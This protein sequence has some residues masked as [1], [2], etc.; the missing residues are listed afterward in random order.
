MYHISASRTVC[1]GDKMTR[2]RSVWQVAAAL[3][4]VVVILG[5]VRRLNGLPDGL[6]G[7]YY[8]TTDW[9]GGAVL[10]AVDK[11]PS[12]AAMLSAWDPHSPAGVQRCVDELAPRARRTRRRR[13][14]T[15]SELLARLRDAACQYQNRSDVPRPDGAG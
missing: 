1:G 11:Q 13:V 6:T 10:V 2:V 3:T 15:G 12:T 5:A 4:I 9:T 8:R 7:T 14:R